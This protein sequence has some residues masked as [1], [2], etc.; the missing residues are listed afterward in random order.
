MKPETINAFRDHGEVRP[1]L[2]Q[3]LDET[4]SGLEHLAELGVDI[5]AITEKLQVDGVKSFTDSYN[6]L[7]ASLQEKKIKFS[8]SHN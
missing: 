7:L 8:K 4:K 2:E 5:K 1:T 6:K 3:G